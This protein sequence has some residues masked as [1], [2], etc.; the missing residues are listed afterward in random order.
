MA[1]TSHD[2]LERSDEDAPLRAAAVTSTAIRVP[3]IELL[4]M[5]DCLP[6]V[7]WPTTASDRRWTA[8]VD[9][10]VETRWP[11]Q[12]CTSADDQPITFRT[13]PNRGLARIRRRCVFIQ[14]WPP[15]CSP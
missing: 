5:T 8:N 4:R 14:R 10:A 6:A 1:R 11:P 3:T 2:G 7:D 13:H 15:R 12:W 9:R